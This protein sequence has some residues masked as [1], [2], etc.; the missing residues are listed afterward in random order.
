MDR[1]PILYT[2]QLE[3]RQINAGDIASLVR[4]AN[5]KQIADQI[6]N[7]PHPYEEYH[8]VHRLSY[9][10]R[11]F[12]EGAFYAFAIILREQEQ[13]IGEISLHLKPEASAELGYWIGEPF[14]NQ[15]FASEAIS[16][17][18]A[19]GFNKLGL[20][21]IYAEC[22]RDNAASIRVLLKNH[23]GESG[24]NTLPVLRYEL[25]VPSLRSESPENLK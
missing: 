2:N 13:F 19:F 14:W 9:V 11:G 12:K 21:Q 4:L 20:S 25:F 23:F 10:Y 3:L 8:A 5:N 22:H 7:M 18:T 15:G 16:A 6:I 1:F 17:I 24:N